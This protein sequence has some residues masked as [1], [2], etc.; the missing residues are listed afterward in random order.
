[1]SVFCALGFVL[2]VAP[3][4]RSE[5]CLD[6][7]VAF[8]GT[9][10]IQMIQDGDNYWRP[11]YNRMC[12]DYQVCPA[13]DFPKGC[14]RYDSGEVEKDG[15]SYCKGFCRSGEYTAVING[16]TGDEGIT[17]SFCNPY[18]CLLPG[19]SS[20]T[21]PVNE[22]F[23]PYEFFSG[24]Y[25]NNLEGRVGSYCSRGECN[26]FGCNCDGGCIERSRRKLS[27]VTGNTTRSEE[28]GVVGKCQQAMIDK[29][30]TYSLTGSQIREYFDCLDSN[31]NNRLDA[32]D[33]AHK[34]VLNLTGGSERL[35][36]MDGDGN[37]V[38]DASEFDSDISDGVPMD[39]GTGLINRC[40]MFHLVLLGLVIVVVLSF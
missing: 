19:E 17:V 9:R 3:F 23:C 24:V 13:S 30:N 1:M 25:C 36:A 38:I 4:V 14:Q 7:H 27:E 22:A 32:D 8:S 37:G 11:L 33:E 28:G 26:M 39:T 5:C 2:F 10:V 21:Q 15:I 18:I 31:T 12:Q 40:T 20:A 29:F 34:Y 16:A 35:A 6:K